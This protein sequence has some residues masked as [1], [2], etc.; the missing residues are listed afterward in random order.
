MHDKKL[1]PSE[2]W[3]D[4]FG[5]LHAAIKVLPKRAEYF[6]SLEIRGQHAIEQGLDIT[7]PIVQQDIAAQAYVDASRAIYMQENCSVT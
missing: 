7:D 1:Y 3:L 5:Q 2:G 4:F 6:R